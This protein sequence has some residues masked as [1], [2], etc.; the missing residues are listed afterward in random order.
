MSPEEVAG[1]Y[2]E[3]CLAELGA[4]KPG[5]VHHF[6]PG[7]GMT[8]GDFAAS[9][10]ASAAAISE[11]GRRVGERVHEAARRTRVAVGFNTNLGILLLAGPLAEAAMSGGPG[12]LAARLR[13]ALEALGVEDAEEVFAAIRL[14][15]P[16]GLGSAARHDVRAPAQVPLGV[17]MAAA[18][19]RDRI[20]YQYASGFADIFE[21]GLPRLRRGL[22]AWNDEPAA[23]CSAYL[24][25]LSS[26]PDS[27]VVRKLGPDAAEDLRR[28]AE[29]L[30]AALLAAPQPAALRGRLLAVDARLKEEGVNPGASADLTVASL[31]ALRLERALSEE[32]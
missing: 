16:G 31:F 20:A 11:P 32:A 18:A 25:F 23:A 22:E 1:A 24:G 4:L 14:A 26:F 7:H 28:E 12:D 6:A 9:A 30:D 17:A 5:N 8:A 27:H 10:K 2:L 21:L 19:G 13:R 3:A 15:S 29:G